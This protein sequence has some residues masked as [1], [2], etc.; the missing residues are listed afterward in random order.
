MF[1][2]PKD[3]LKEVFVGPN[4]DPHKVF[5]RLGLHLWRLELS[6]TGNPGN[7]LWGFENDQQFFG[8]TYGFLE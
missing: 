2:S 3:L 8:E 5:G 1:G 4:T 6:A 7:P